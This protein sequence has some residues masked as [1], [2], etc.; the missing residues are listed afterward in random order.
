MEGQTDDS[1][2]SIATQY[3]QYDWLKTVA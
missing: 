2:M 1:M 3:V